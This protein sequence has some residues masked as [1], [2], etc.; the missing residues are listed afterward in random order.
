MKFFRHIYTKFIKFFNS[1]IWKSFI[2][3]HLYAN[4]D[5]WAI[6]IPI[7]TVIFFC[8]FNTIISII[9]CFKFCIFIKI[10]YE[11]LNLCVCPDTTIDDR[12]I[13]L[14]N[15]ELPMLVTLSGIVMEVRFS[16]YSKALSPILVKLYQE[17]S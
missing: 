5:F 14:V 1:I 10:R 4:M 2:I 3:L 13:Q 7:W 12:F 16:H 8:Y 17:W 11:F 15:V 6:Y 9:D